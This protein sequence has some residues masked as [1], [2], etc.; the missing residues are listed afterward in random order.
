MKQTEAFCQTQNLL[1]LQGLI[2]GAAQE[3]D[4][5]HKPV[6]WADFKTDA[7]CRI[8]FVVSCTFNQYETNDS[9]TYVLKV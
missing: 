4:Q 3:E 9:Y 2:L 6:K 5:T 1:G 8:M 7:T